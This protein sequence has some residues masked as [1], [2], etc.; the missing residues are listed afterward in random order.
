[1]AGAAFYWYSGDHF[2]ALRLVREKYPKLKLILSESCLEY[3]KFDADHIDESIGRLTH[4]IMGDL[5][6]GMCAFYDWN[7]LLDE[8]GRP[9]HVGNFCHAPFL[10]DTK[11]KQ[12]LPQETLTQFHHFAHYIHE[13][14]VRIAVTGYTGK[15][16]SAAYRRPEGSYLLLLSNTSAEALPIHVRIDNEAAEILL[17]GGALASCVISA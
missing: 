2:E 7:F 13:G 3:R 8:Q 14:S 10:Y 5:N 4:E 12:L 15:L 16:E 17:Q 6:A 9:N 1:M 11:K